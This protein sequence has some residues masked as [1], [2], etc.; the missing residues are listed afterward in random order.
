MLAFLRQLG[1]D[2][3]AKMGAGCALVLFG[4]LHCGSEVFPLIKGK[5]F[6]SFLQLV[7]VSLFFADRLLK[8]YSKK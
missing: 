8:N 5:R 4:H 6:S 1:A 7:I 2:V 3:K